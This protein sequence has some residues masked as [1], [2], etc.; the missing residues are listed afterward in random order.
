MKNEI[1]SERKINEII[2]RFY[3]F[4]AF[5]LWSEKFFISNHSFLFV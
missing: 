3:G 1:I 4:I 2:K 5:S